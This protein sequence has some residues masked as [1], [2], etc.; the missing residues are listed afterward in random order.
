MIFDIAVFDGMDELDAVGPL[1]VLRSAAERGA[2]FDVQLVTLEPQSRIRC[3]HGLA[4]V[5]DGVCRD[6]AD[7]LIFPGGGWV[8]RSAKGARTEA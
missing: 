5:P 2:P 3:A 8:A 1:E 6:S 7:I 4:M